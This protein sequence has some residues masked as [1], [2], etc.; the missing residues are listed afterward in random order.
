M[1]EVKE[2]QSKLNAYKKLLEVGK[3]LHSTLDLDRL[4][5]TTLE[6]TK[7]VMNAEAGSFFLLDEKNNQLNFVTV[8][9]SA[10]KKLTSAPPIKV[11][12]GIVGMV[13]KTGLP[14]L[15]LSLPN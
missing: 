6:K 4:L 2:L 9:G 3:Q 7:S 13:A 14:F 5:K 10:K 11:G 12:E 8:S 1:K 15:L